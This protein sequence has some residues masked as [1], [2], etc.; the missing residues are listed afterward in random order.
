MSETTV[1]AVCSGLSEG[2]VSVLNCFFGSYFGIVLQRSQL[3]IMWQYLLDCRKCLQLNIVQFAKISQ[4]VAQS[5]CSELDVHDSKIQDQLFDILYSP[6]G[7]ML[8]IV[9][10]SKLLSLFSE[11]PLLYYFILIQ[12]SSTARQKK[13]VATFFE[14]VFRPLSFVCAIYPWL[15]HK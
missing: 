12:S 7:S 4:L 2:T 1:R 13:N 5:I 10:G 6:G 14:Y 9:E 11:R 3:T 15:G 8:Y